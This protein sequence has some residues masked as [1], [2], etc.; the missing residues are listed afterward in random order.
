MR[1][2]S[3]ARGSAIKGIRIDHGQTHAEK[4]SN[5]VHLPLI[6]GEGARAR[7]AGA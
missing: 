1:K 4:R 2:R 3:R 6:G 7:G 5:H